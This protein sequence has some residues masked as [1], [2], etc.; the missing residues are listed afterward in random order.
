MNWHDVQKQLATL[1]VGVSAIIAFVFLS[2]V[3]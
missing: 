2:R 1:A 3:F